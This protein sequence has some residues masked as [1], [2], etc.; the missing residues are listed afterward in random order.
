MPPVVVVEQPNFLRIRLQLGERENGR[1]IIR[2]LSYRV[3]ENANHQN[4]YDVALAIGGLV[5][6]PVYDVILTENKLLTE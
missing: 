1:P 4:I 2:S 3:K 5:G 6:Y